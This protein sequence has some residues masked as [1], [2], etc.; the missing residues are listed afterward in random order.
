VIHQQDARPNAFDG[1]EYGHRRAPT[2]VLLRD[3][4]LR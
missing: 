3:A 4:G 2:S 1:A